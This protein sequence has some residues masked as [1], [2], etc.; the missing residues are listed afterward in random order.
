MQR[1]QNTELQQQGVRI[2]TQPDNAK[3]MLDLVIE[4]TSEG[5]KK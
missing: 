2:M 4:L 3:K 5:D 1:M